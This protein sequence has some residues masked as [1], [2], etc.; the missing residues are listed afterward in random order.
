MPDPVPIFASVVDP[1]PDA[2]DEKYG[3]PLL[4]EAG[5]M[6]WA[7]DLS[8]MPSS[9]QLQWLSG[10][11][12]E[13]ADRFHQD[14]DRT[15]YLAAHV[16]LRELL[17]LQCKQAPGE[18]HLMKDAY[19]KWR[20]EGA[21][22]WDFSMSYAENIGLIAIVSD[23]Q[24]GVD[25]EMRQDIDDVA[26]LADFAF[27]AEEKEELFRLARPEISLAFLRGWTRKEACLKALGTGLHFPPADFHTGIVAQ[28]SHVRGPF[29]GD[30]QVQNFD[31][32]EKFVAAWALFRSGAQPAR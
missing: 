2:R 18:Q 15:R 22:D 21:T 20:M 16:A 8:T 11:E 3:R 27:A 13:R 24:V 19:G 4:L 17:A 9:E 25:I 12:E 10:E 32:G 14:K 28:H 6:V 30:L 23:C 7:I 5:P 1:T 29:V 26:E 31:V